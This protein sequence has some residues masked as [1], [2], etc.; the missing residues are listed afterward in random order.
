MAIS[1]E[2]KRSWSRSGARAVEVGS[3]WPTAEEAERTPKEEE[4][5][6]NIKQFVGGAVGST[7][8]TPPAGGREGGG[9]VKS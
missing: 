7:T 5:E 2:E 3:R 1:D 8:T 9:R 6:R 4:E